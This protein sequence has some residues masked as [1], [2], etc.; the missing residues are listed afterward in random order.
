MTSIARLSPTPLEI[1][2]GRSVKNVK[3][4]SY[5]PPSRADADEPNRAGAVVAGADRVGL[6]LTDAARQLAT[7]T[8]TPRLDAELLMAHALST[9]RD[10]LLLRRLDDAAPESFAALVR[11]RLSH[12]PVAYIT[13]TRA[14]WTIDLWV[15]PGTLVPRPDSETLIEAAIGH[16]GERA[17]AAVLDLGTGP[18]TLLLAALD[19]WQGATGLG[20]DASQAALNYARANAERLGM[21]ARAAFRIGDWTAGVEGMFDLI[22]ANPP[23]IGTDEP[24]PREVRDHEPASAL[25]AGA[26]GLDDYRRILPDLRR[27][28]APGGCA[29]L[30]IGHRQAEAVSTLAA[31]HGLLPH[32]HTDLGNRPRAILLT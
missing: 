22:L 21:A 15:G 11:R 14:F 9:T 16:F 4:G 7:I 27:L 31:R 23:Y 12:E 25:F 24:L 30:E 8:D 10:D 26:D 2:R 6:A 18:G 28:I 20:I 3:N 1:V 32:V 13:G 19:Q 29:V 5:S 17:P